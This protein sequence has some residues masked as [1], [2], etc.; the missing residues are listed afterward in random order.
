[1]SAPVPPRT[2]HRLRA[3]RLAAALAVL[4]LAAAGCTGG[5]A[6]DAPAAAPTPTEPAAAT[7]P[8]ASSPTTRPGPEADPEPAATSV[9]GEEWHTDSNGDG[10]PDF[11][12]LELGTDPEDDGCAADADCPGPAAAGALELDR[13]RNVLLLLDASGSMVG[14]AGG[15]V[16]KMEAA[17][18][19]L[20]RYVLGTPDTVRIGFGVYGHLGSNQPEGKAESCAGVELLEPIGGIDHAAFPE[21]LA[22]FE[23]VGFTPLA[24]AIAAAADAFA[25]VD[26][27]ADNRVIVV[28]D[29]IETCDGDPV[30]E[31]QALVDAGIGLTLD[32]VGFDVPDAESAQLRRIAEVG[33]GTYVDART[34]EALDDYFEGQRQQWLALNDQFICIL[35]AGNASHS[36]LVRLQQAA[37]D[38][39]TEAAAAAETAEERREILQL[40]SA[41]HR[42]MIDRSSAVSQDR[43]GQMAEVRRALDEVA[44]RMSR[45]YGEDVS[46]DLPCTGGLLLARWA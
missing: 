15:G 13:E 41:M 27:E 4:A 23:A 5:P 11:M 44:R 28:S 36:C 16:T 24:G 22:R 25:D 39:F 2:A 38:R 33:G 9:L 3:R 45:R 19:A 10:I 29:G 43:R 35:N 14:S 20:E 6:E 32:V 21:T 42:E 1:V 46:A 8:P 40:R 34:N 7:P 17:K 12:A 18:A 37:F 31:A 26:P 30:A